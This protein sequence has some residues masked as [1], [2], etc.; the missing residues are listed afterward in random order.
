MPSF[1]DALRAA[2]RA[3][4]ARMAAVLAL[5]AA[6]ATAAT[7]RSAR[8]QQ[9][10]QGF[11]VER[12]YQSAPG[13]GWVVMD[14]LDMHGGLGGVMA[15]SSG[16]AHD[17]LRV[18]SPDGTQRL[19]AIP[20]R[21]SSTSVL[22][23]PTSAGASISISRARCS[24]RGR[25]RRRAPRS[26]DTRSRLRPSARSGIRTRSRTRGWA[27]MCDFWV[28]PPARF[29]SD[30]AGSSGF[31]LVTARTPRFPP[32]ARSTVP[33]APFGACCAFCSPE[34]RAP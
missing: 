33:M 24:S 13:G 19:A 2:V 22:R 3:R 30:S 29:A 23:S 32:C 14:A 18:A 1:S 10:A 9:A 16:Y 11:A 34:M 6:M 20:M 26:T 12:L 4:R 28:S 5:A 15:L 31:P 7:G 27:S 21:R 25:A 17:P 8:A